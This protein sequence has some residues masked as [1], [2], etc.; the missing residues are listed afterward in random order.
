MRGFVSCVFSEI[1]KFIESVPFRYFIWD[2]INTNSRG[3]R[4]Y[5]FLGYALTRIAGSGPGA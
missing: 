4:A 5:H 1:N 2:P 3:S